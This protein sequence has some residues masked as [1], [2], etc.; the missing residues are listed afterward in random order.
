[1]L[2]QNVKIRSTFPFSLCHH[3]SL[4]LFISFSFCGSIFFLFGSLVC[5][6]PAIYFTTISSMK[7]Y[8]FLWAT[9]FQTRDDNFIFWLIALWDNVSISLFLFLMLVFF[10]CSSF[11]AVHQV[12]SHSTFC[13][14]VTLSF[15]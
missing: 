14:L 6:D 3:N 2:Q 11:V 10:P 5:I 7:P 8:L 1:M 15:I 4:R 12:P 13:A 9:T